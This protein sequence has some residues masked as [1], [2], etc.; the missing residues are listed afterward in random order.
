MSDVELMSHDKIGPE[1]AAKYLQNGTTAQEIRVKA[2]NGNCPF[3]VA[4]KMS[5]RY[6]YRIN[7]GL[8]VK[9]KSGELGLC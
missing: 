1:L 2:Q 3:C 8:L 7:P 5:G 6:R 9:Y 4:E